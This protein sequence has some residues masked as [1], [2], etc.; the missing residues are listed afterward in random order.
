MA[1]SQSVTLPARQL[2]QIVVQRCQVLSKRGLLFLP[3]YY[4]RHTIG[5]TAEEDLS[6]SG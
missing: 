4:S 5:P 1:P 3:N 6:G 2:R